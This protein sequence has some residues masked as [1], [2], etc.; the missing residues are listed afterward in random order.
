MG[1]FSRSNANY[2]KMPHMRM[3]I[4]AIFLVFVGILYVGGWVKTKTILGN[5]SEAEIKLIVSLNSGEDLGLEIMHE[6]SVFLTC[7]L[8]IHEN[9]PVSLGFFGFGSICSSF[10]CCRIT[11]I[12]CMSHS[13]NLEDVNDR[14]S[15]NKS[16]SI[17]RDMGIYYYICQANSILRFD[18]APF[19]IYK[20]SVL[21]ALKHSYSGRL[22]S[23]AVYFFIFPST[24]RC[25][26]WLH[27]AIYRMRKKN[28]LIS[29]RRRESCVP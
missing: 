13:S 16:L 1:T 15:V 17:I 3:S 26:L 28:V 24:Q 29:N 5:D 2:V 23:V 12:T 18:C 8:K 27:I 7:P 22:F 20:I 14:N 11:W 10:V 6:N 9:H 25:A 21:S 19:T 4:S